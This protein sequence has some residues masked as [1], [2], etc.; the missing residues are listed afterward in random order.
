MDLEYIIIF[1]YKTS[2]VVRGY[3]KNQHLETFELTIELLQCSFVI[4]V[5][6]QFICNMHKLYI[7]ITIGS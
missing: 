2:I 6:P 1:L 5:L 3:N 4:D 7:E